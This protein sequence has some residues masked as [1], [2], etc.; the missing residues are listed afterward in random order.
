[1]LLILASFPRAHERPPNLVTRA[2][3]TRVMNGAQTASSTAQSTD[4][5]LDT[6][7]RQLEEVDEERVLAEIAKLDNEIIERQ[8]RVATRRRLLE[9][10][11]IYGSSSRE[12]AE[13]ASANANRRPVGSS[14]AAAESR[15]QPATDPSLRQLSAKEKRQ[16]VFDIMSSEQG[17][18]TPIRMRD[19]FMGR[20]LDPH[21]G[22]AL[23]NIMWNLWKHGRLARSD[24]EAGYQ[25]PLP[26]SGEGLLSERE[27]E[28]R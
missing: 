18:W 10:K 13:S 5:L 16:Q 19:A 2:R 23:R 20:G 12:P 11:R 8:E 9:M 21:Y 3:V 1:M 24:D 14:D 22:T 4:A 17:V 15:E 25:L 7:A 6:L 28:D 26:S 27:G